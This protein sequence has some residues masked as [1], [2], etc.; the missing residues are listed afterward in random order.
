MLVSEADDVPRGAERARV[1]DEWFDGFHHGL[2]AAFWRAAGATM[3]EADAALVLKLLE[4]EPG[5]FRK[6]GRAHV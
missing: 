2:A 3:A 5:S 4:L 6:I 1:P